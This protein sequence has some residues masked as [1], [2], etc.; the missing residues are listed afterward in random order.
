MTSTI[1]RNPPKPYELGA[2]KPTHFIRVNKVGE[3]HKVYTHD[4][5]LACLRAAFPRACESDLAKMI[6]DMAWGKSVEV[7]QAWWRACPRG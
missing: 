5:T 3:L 4:E 1:K 6:C 7:N 2:M